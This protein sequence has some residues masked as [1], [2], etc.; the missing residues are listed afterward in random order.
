LW[1]TANC[2]NKNVTPPPLFFAWESGIAR[3][4]P[5]PK[6][7]T[8]RIRRRSHLQIKRGSSSP[9]S[10]VS[11][12]FVSPRVHPRVRTV[13]TDDNE[14]NGTS[15]PKAGLQAHLRKKIRE[16]LVL[17]GRSRIISLKDSRSTKPKISRKE[18]HMFYQL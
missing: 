6:R 18:K 12:S 4:S 5:L 8:H 1:V 2:P 13:H 14:W 10:R 11:L 7:D 3:T 16:I 9:G 15:A 17:L